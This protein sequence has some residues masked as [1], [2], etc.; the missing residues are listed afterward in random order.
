MHVYQDI[1]ANTT[2]KHVPKTQPNWAKHHVSDN[3]P[4][5]T[6]AVIMCA[7]ALIHVPSNFIKQNK[8]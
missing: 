8:P 1:T 2:S 5:P 6:T 7:L 3:T 4:D